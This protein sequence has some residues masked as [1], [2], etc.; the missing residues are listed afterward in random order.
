MFYIFHHSV[1]K[2]PLK[3]PKHNIIGLLLDYRIQTVKIATVQIRHQI[4][5]ITIYAYT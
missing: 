2:Y 4:Y 5:R 1:S 3:D